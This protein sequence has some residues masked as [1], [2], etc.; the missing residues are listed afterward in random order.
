MGFKY[1]IPGS[2]YR[3]GGVCVFAVYGNTIHRIGNKCGVPH[4]SPVNC[5]KASHD[6]FY[7]RGSCL[8]LACLVMLI[9]SRQ[10]EPMLFLS[11]NT[12]YS[13]AMSNGKWY[14]STAFVTLVYMIND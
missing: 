9:V 11:A 4:T 1:I 6:Y 7:Q 8:R 13:C 12:W 2:F 10:D 3:G 5:A 14:G